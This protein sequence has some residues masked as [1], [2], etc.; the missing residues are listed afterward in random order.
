MTKIILIVVMLIISGCA[1]NVVYV[2]H[3]EE[4]DKGIFKCEKI[5]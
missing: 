5:D 1:S 3:C 2:K 4:L